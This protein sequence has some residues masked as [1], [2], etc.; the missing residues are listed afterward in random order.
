MSTFVLRMNFICALSVNNEI[1]YVHY[2]KW[3]LY[4]NKRI[5][6]TLGLAMLADKDL[7]VIMWHLKPHYTSGQGL[8]DHIVL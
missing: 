8:G 2:V 7:V 3:L 1:E 4:E 6:N 5:N